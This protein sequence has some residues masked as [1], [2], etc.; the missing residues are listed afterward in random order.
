M[1]RVRLRTVSGESRQ[2][3]MGDMPEAVWTEACASLNELS[4]G[5]SQTE[6]DGYKVGGIIYIC[7]AT[8]EDLSL[9]HI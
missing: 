6:V 3:I 8:L 5:F 7:A 4:F 9:I 1:S 2:N